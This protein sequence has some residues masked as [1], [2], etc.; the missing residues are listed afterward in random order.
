[1]PFTAQDEAEIAGYPADVQKLI[2]DS[3]DEL[4]HRFDR[5]TAGYTHSERH[6]SGHVIHYGK[7][8]DGTKVQF[9]DTPSGYYFGLS[10]ASWLVI[11]RLSLQEMPLDW[12]A[13]FFR[14]LE[15]ADEKHGLKVPDGLYVMRQG[16]RN[17]WV[18]NSHWNNYRRG[19]TV[20]AIQHD[21]DLGLRSADD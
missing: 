19:T 11:P 16:K 5:F 6:E 17:R 14:L 18:D 1:M 3:M 15:E 9:G 8:A 20:F 10:Y 12:Q 21:I 2:R 7:A 13:K 4:E